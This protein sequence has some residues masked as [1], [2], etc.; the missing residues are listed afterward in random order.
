MKILVLSKEVWR[1]DTNGGNVLSNMFSGFNAEFAQIYCASGTPSNNICKRYFQITPKEA[2]KNF[3]RH[4]AVGVE[5]VFDDFPNDTDIDR[6]EEQSDKKIHGFF[7]KHSWGMFHAFEDLVWNTSNW[8]N[9]KLTKFI[10]DFAPDIIF[11]PC[12]GNKFMLKLTRFVAKRTGK[13]VI[14]YI[15]DDS[16]TLRQF[17]LSPY[18]W[19]RRLGVRRQLRKTFP[20]YSLVYT[21]T[22]TQKTQCEKDFG[23]NMK[24][25]R[26]SGICSDEP[27]KTT[28]T[29]IKMVYAGG[30]YCNRWKTLKVV[31]DALRVINKDGLKATLSV[32]TGNP[33]NKKINKALNDGQSS[34]I[35]GA[36]SQGNLREIY[37]DS[38]IA[39][40]V[41]SFDL[42]N[43]LAVRM[44]FSTKI[45]D[46][47]ASG[48]AV[49]AI[50]DKKQGGYEYLKSEN[51]AICID[52]LKKLKSVLQGVVENPDVI[53]EYRVLAK[54]CVL[55]NHD[56]N[57][58]SGAVKSDFLSV[59]SE[60]KDESISD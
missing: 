4:G 37:R 13:K 26:K 34:V 14:S 49:M 59:I 40:H 7:H 9:K 20:Y 45:V 33:I 5:R 2:V 23:A 60:N 31:A 39:L 46:C 53:D 38:D 18:F 21:M 58:I 47:L 10:D 28:T 6:K 11:A 12:Y 51:A 19:I 15:S 29:P 8:K 36:V 17:S 24:I 44:S 30:I 55:R 22:E 25:L 54:E 42:K 56:F 48:C 27:L 50:C 3:F 52:D 57:A 32:Y 41:E 1:D 16:Y 35:C 43:R